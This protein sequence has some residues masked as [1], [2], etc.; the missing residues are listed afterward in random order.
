MRLDAPKGQ[1][2]V[3]YHA[4]VE[5]ITVPVPLQLDEALVTTVPNDALRHLMPSRYCKSDILSRAAPRCSCSAICH[6]A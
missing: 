4:N 1:L 6:P 2:S 5:L 3:N